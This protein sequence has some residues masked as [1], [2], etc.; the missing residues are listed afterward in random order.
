[1]EDIRIPG[2]EDA[3]YQT[4]RTSGKVEMREFLNLIP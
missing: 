1:M 3:G 4:T 2:N